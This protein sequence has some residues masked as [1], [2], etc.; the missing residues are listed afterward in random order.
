MRLDHNIILLLM[1]DK[2]KLNEP[3]IRRP[4]FDSWDR[5]TACFEIMFLKSIGIGVHM[6]IKLHQL[7]IDVI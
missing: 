6:K 1:F 3:I 2:K 5:L 4:N 7:I